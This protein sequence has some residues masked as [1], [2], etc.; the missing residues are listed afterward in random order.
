MC[1]F[2][3]W[4]SA[5]ENSIEAFVPFECSKVPNVRDSRQLGSLKVVIE[6]TLMR[7]PVTM[8]ARFAAVE[9]LVKFAAQRVQ[10]IELSLNLKIVGSEID[11]A[12]SIFARHG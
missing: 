11:H 2:L 8:L 7:V 1:Q 9:S 4:L 12:S 10:T 3:G 5:K 6:C